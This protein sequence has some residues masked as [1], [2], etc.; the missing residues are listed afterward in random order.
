MLF[1]SFS[2]NTTDNECILQGR[3]STVRR[4]AGENSNLRPAILLLLPEIAVKSVVS[5]VPSG[6]LT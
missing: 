1:Q 3:W 4:C 6:Q 2:H 5:P